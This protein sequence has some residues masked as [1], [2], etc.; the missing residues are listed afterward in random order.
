VKGACIT[1]LQ[2]ELIPKTSWGVNLRSKLKK[3]DWDKIRKSVYAKENMY[4]HICGEKCKSLDAHEMW[5]FDEENHIQRLI[6]IIGI[7]KPCHHT[8]HYGLAQIIGKAKEAREQFMKVNNY[9]DFVEFEMELMRAQ[10][11]FIRRSK[12][13]DWKLDVSLIER[14]GYLVNK[15]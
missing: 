5:E 10:G 3:S 6:D 13:K 15:D 12:I 7:C 4:C 9:D 14:H 2:I 11:D 8:I 1:K